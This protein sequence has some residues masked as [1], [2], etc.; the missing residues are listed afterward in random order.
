[1]E[2]E[3]CPGPNREVGALF[4]QSTGK[5]INNPQTPLMEF[6]PHGRQ[7]AHLMGVETRGY[8]P[9]GLRKWRLLNR[10]VTGASQ[11]LPSSQAGNGV[12]N[13]SRK[14]KLTGTRKARLSSEKNQ[15][16]LEPKVGKEH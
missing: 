8:P 13:S 9:I 12:N 16:G 2:Q 14:V 5:W 1:M 6:C 15:N 4:D 3:M 11:E 10:D 7:Y